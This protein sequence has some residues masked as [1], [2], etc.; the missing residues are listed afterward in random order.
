MPV[1]L[2]PIFVR[3][4]IY[5]ALYC[6][7]LIGNGTLA[8]TDVVTF[9]SENVGEGLCCIDVLEEFWGSSCRTRTMTTTPSTNRHTLPYLNL[10]HIH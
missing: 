8:N 7:F 5:K 10:S 6:T 9:H 1:P 2:F 3:P 4:A